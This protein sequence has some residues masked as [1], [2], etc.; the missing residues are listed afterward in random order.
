VRTLREQRGA[1]LTELVT[2]IAVIGVILA[3]FAPSFAHALSTTSNV[4]DEQNLSAAW[5]A[6][7]RVYLTSSPSLYPA[8]GQLATMLSQ[9]ASDAGTFV[10][11]GADPTTPGVIEVTTDQD[12]QL[13]LCA[14]ASS[15]GYLTIR[16]DGDGK[17]LYGKGDSCTAGANPASPGVAQSPLPPGPNEVS[18]AIWPF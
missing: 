9:A 11:T 13:L 12:R 5:Q 2:V 15:G 14:Q 18:A 1:T 10:S 8:S 17:P 3:V 4:R 7:R 6:A 16:D